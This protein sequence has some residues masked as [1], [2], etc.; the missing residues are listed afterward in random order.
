MWHAAREAVERARAGE[1]P[2]LLEAMTFRFHG[3]YFGDAAA[4][5]PK[6]ELQAAMDRDPMPV[7]RASVIA[8]GAA[9]EA[10]LEALTQDINAQIDDAL[11]FAADSPTPEL[12][13]ID[14]D[15]YAPGVS[16]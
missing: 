12:A 9:S 15:I 6:A 7:L 13:E 2:T 16:A 10:D 5:I 3:H 4:Y 14:R 11:K 8:S 1:G